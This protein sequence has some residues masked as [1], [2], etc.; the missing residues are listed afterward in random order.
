[1]MARLPGSGTADV[2]VRPTNSKASCCGREHQL[3]LPIGVHEPLV[4]SHSKAA[5]LGALDVVSQPQVPED[6]GAVS[7]ISSQ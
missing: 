4:S 2:E 6:F 3:V 5:A 7:W 1:M